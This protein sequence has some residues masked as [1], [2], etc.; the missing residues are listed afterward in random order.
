MLGMTWHRRV[1]MFS[2]IGSM[3]S[4]LLVLP[5]LLAEG[6]L[7]LLFVVILLLAVFGASSWSFM[8]LPAAEG[9]RHSDGTSERPAH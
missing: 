5:T 4:A 7:T 3:I 2:C 8:T 9:S 6:S 1:L